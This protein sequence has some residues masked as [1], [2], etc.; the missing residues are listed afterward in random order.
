[1]KRFFFLLAL[2]PSLVLAVTPER[3]LPKT[4]VIK[5]V[6]WYAA[7]KQ[8]WAS[9]AKSGTAQAWFNYYAAAVFA[10]SSR[11]DLSQILN[12][13]RCPIQSLS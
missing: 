6:T 11:D 4:L 13:M 3:I 1:M 5:P 9:E 10:Q 7:Q 2:I 12:D 8:A